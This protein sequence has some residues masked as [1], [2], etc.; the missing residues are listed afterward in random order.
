MLFH[1]GKAKT[2]DKGNLTKKQNIT[3][4]NTLAPLVLKSLDVHFALAARKKMENGQERKIKAP[5]S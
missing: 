5:I 3:F 1:I 2:S 4:E